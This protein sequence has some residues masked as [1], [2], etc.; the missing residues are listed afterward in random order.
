[1]IYRELGEPRVKRKKKT[2]AKAKGK[3]T[4]FSIEPAPGPV[5][6]DDMWALP[7]KKDKKKNLA[8]EPQPEVAKDGFSLP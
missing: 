6:N 7:T 3:A 5:I 2:K 8:P 1:M 4:D